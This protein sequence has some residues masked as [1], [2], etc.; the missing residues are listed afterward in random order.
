MNTIYSFE[1]GTGV[2]KVIIRDIKQVPEPF[3]LPIEIQK[4]FNQL[5]LKAKLLVQ[6]A[7]VCDN[8]FVI[9][10]SHAVISIGDVYDFNHEV[11][12]AMANFLENYYGKKSAIEFYMEWYPD[13]RK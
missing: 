4:M 6:S 2:F 9:T 13:L 12:I 1:S 7:Y 5:P 11:S 3:E 10:L 8:S